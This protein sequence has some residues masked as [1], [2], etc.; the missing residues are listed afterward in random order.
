MTGTGGG[1]GEGSEE[2]PFSLGLGLELKK[3]FTRVPVRRSIDFDLTLSGYRLLPL[4]RRKSV[5]NVLWT[6]EGMGSEISMIV[7]PDDRR[8]RRACFDVC[9]CFRRLEHIA[10]VAAA[11][12]PDTRPGKKPATT[13]VTGNAGHFSVTWVEFGARPAKDVGVEEG[14][15]DKVEVGAAVD[16]VDEVDE[17]DEIDEVDEVDDADEVGKVD[18]ADG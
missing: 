14:T 6:S 4:R 7:P 15:I 17:A 2:P 3:L 1:G 13:A 8:R 11:R 10:I 5:R 9:V 18:E 12:A 16:E